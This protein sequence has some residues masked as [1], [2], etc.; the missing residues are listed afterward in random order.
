MTPV[1]ADTSFYLSLL[2][3]R[4][5]AHAKA[6]ALAGEFR[7]PTIVT[8]FVLLEVG[9]A[10]SGS[11]R[12]R[13]RFLALLER[14]TQSRRVTVI[15]ATSELFHRGVDLYRKRRD[16]GWSITD[17]AS[18]VIMKQM[19]LTEALTGDR[20]FEQAGFIVLLK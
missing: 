1:F 2:N 9:N 13:D 17:C 11:A 7:R 3:P 5:A 10:M 12:G 19:G 18:F 8:E 15:P 4:D 14:L 20:H 6:S 16:K